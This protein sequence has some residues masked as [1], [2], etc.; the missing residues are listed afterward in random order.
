MPVILNGRGGDLL[1]IF[2]ESIVDR[3][4]FKV[5]HSI[6]R[7][8]SL[9]P[10]DNEGLMVLGPHHVITDGCNMWP[11]HHYLGVDL[12]TRRDDIINFHFLT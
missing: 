9:K 12:R 4:A 11:S 7:A 5:A 3:S 2:L 6:V 10:L 1:L 8:S